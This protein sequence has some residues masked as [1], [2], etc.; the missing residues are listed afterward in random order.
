MGQEQYYFTAYESA[1]EFIETIEQS[2]LK[3]SV[4]E[5]NCLFNQYYQQAK[6]QLNYEPQFALDTTFDLKKQNHF[7]V[8]WVSQFGKE[9]Q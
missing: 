2:R 7:L 1:L 8:K 4:E 3:I 6:L 5:Y 9:F